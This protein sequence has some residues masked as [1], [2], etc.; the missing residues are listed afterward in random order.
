MPSFA[1]HLMRNPW[2]SRIYERAWRPVFTRG[3]SLGSTETTDYDTALRAYLCRPGERMVLDIAC[4]PGNYTR[5]I[6]DGLT[7]TG[8]AVGVDSAPSMLHTAVATN[9]ACPATYLRVDA[10]AIPFADNTF[11]E[12]LCLAALY[13]IDN[14]LPVLDE[15]LR[16]T[17]PGGLIV[18]F[19]SAPGPVAALPGVSTLATLGG[20]R[21]FGRDEITGALRRFGAEHI[22][23]IVIGEG[24][25]VLAR[26]P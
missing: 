12:T 19:T 9:A 5:R 3:F 18:V 1:A 2:F 14:P 4:G 26:K 7:G 16:V 20:F 6:A 8:R 13:L 25:Y 24:Q 22:E 17:Q 23:Q 11:D 10:H 15:M 21:I